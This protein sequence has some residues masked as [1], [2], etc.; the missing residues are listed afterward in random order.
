MTKGIEQHKM[1]SGSF[2]AVVI[3]PVIFSTASLE[4]SDS[5]MG[6][7]LSLNQLASLYMFV[8]FFCLYRNVPVYVYVILFP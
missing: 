6:I 4:G 2:V 7:R 5:V 8:I 3:R 1:I